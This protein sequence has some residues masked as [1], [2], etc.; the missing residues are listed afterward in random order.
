MRAEQDARLQAERDA[1]RAA[2]KRIWAE[3]GERWEQMWAKDKAS[4]HEEVSRWR[5]AT[6]VRPER[7]ECGET[8]QTVFSDSADT[9][10]SLS[11]LGRYP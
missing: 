8:A 9:G 3:S 6:E 7:R 4:L 2:V 11:L 1:E 10:E 5:D